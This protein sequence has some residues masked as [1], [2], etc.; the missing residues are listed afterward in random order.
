MAGATGCAGTSFGIIDVAEHSINVLPFGVHDMVNLDRIRCV[1]LRH[2]RESAQELAGVLG[3]EKV[4][5]LILPVTTNDN[6]V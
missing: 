1:F 6:T 2:I 5:A 4:L 3:M